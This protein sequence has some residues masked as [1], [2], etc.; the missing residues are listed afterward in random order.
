MKDKLAIIDDLRRQLQLN[1]DNN[2]L[3]NSQVRFVGNNFWPYTYFIQCHVFK[4]NYC[5]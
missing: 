4:H 2:N 3:L 1:A 5:F